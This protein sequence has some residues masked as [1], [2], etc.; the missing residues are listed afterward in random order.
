MLLFEIKYGKIGVYALE[1][2]KNKIK[3]Y[4]I[5]KMSRIAPL[6]RVFEATEYVTPPNS[7]LLVTTPSRKENYISS[8]QFENITF[9]PCE[10][11]HRSVQ[12][13][14]DYYE[15]RFTNPNQPYSTIKVEINGSYKYFLIGWQEQGKNTTKPYNHYV[16]KLIFLPKSLYLL[17]AIEQRKFSLIKDEDISEQLTLFNKEKKYDIKISDNLTKCNKKLERGF[18]RQLATDYSEDSYVLKHILS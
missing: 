1:P 2:Q 5:Y 14:N 17:D 12:I 18:Y 3:D 8:K 11:H 7:P 15:G 9:T 6:F 10:S 13:L 4:K 16:P